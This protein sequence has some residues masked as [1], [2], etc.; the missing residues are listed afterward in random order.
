VARKLGLRVA[1]RT[2]ERKST[3]TGSTAAIITTPESLDV[4]LSSRKD[5]QQLLDVG[6]VVIDEAHLL[7]GSARGAQV[8]MLLRR[9]EMLRG[10]EVQK[11]ALSATIGDPTDVAK[12]LA[13]DRA[14]L[15]VIAAGRQREV[16]MT[17]WGAYPNGMDRIANLVR[18]GVRSHGW[19][20]M[21]VFTNTR[22]DADHLA[23]RLAADMPSYPIELHFSSLP[24][25]HRER[26]E[27]RLKDGE[28]GICVATSTLELGIDIGDID[29]VYMY[30]APGSISSFLQ[31]A[32]RSNRGSTTANVVAVPRTH[33]PR[34]GSRPELWARDLLT[35]AAID[36]AVQYGEL[37]CL[38]APRYWS[39]LVQQCFSMARYYEKIGVKPLMEASAAG[40]APFVS[41]EGCR[42]VL[43]HLDELGYLSHHSYG[44]YYVLTDRG[45]AW[46]RSMQIW[47]NFTDQSESVPVLQDSDVLDQVA[48]MNRFLLAPGMLVRVKG[49]TR[50]VISIEPDCI[51]VSEPSRPGTAVPLKRLGQGWPISFEIAQSMK[52]LA[53]GRGLAE[54]SPHIEPGARS[55][56]EDWF[57]RF[58]DIDLATHLPYEVARD[59]VYS[60]FL[61]G[62][63]N[64]V[65]AELL[66]GQGT[67][68]S[69]DDLGI[70]VKAATV[71]PLPELASCEAA[72]QS[73]ASSL[74]P[75]VPTSVHYALLD[76]QLQVEEVASVVSQPE[77]VRQMEALS[78]LEIAEVGSPPALPW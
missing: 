61:G 67:L 22:N 18:Q 70:T 34:G 21:L 24:R 31:R 59:K 53:A 64:L 42:Q 45:W 71:L 63:G 50:E 33:D 2:G 43:E 25:Q 46:L 29:A 13:G 32:G 36:R 76:P 48:A 56:V 73:F 72:F 66:K 28:R 51:R 49:R 35:F 74:A 5:S 4:M 11:A 30:G 78:T 26:V 3:V 17:I 62:L 38:H 1:V 44:D 37:E 54:V 6:L 19:H 14:P 12:W 27:R 60:T 65:V 7:Y 52:S 77:L 8:L 10:C 15:E 41:E 69:P 20:K 39:V 9:L 47:S 16:E 40:S 75:H 55:W 58:R 68:S 57:G 23:E